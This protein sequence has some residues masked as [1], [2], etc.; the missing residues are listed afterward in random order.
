MINH[1]E[2]GNFYNGKKVLVCGASGMTGRNLFELF[3]NMNID[4]YGTQLSKGFDDLETVDLTDKNR[5]DALISG[6]RPDFVFICAAKTYNMAVCKKDPQSM[7][8]PNISMVGNTLES[9]LNNDVKRVLY[10]S[11]A[12]VYQ[13]SYKVLAE[14]D[15]DLNQ[16]P[17]DVYLGVGWMKRYA[18]KLC[19]FYSSIGL[20]TVVVRP[21]NIY[22]RYDKNDDSVSHVVPALIQ[23]ALRR[24]DP[25]VVYGNGRSVK[26]FIYVMDFVEDLATVMALHSTPDP[27]N[28]CSG[29]LISI[30]DVVR[31]IIK[32]TGLSLSHDIKYTSTKHDAVPFRGISN[33][34][35]L[36]LFG[37]KSYTKFETG[38]KET[39]QWFS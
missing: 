26:D 2:L 21:T 38:L 3:K 4:V 33:Q 23:R 31:L 32:N 39:I 16:E 27:I 22:G 35:F 29:E 25:F 18:E 6:I 12:T 13:P 20:Q 34:K 24:E 30:R 7:V 15:L 14:E 11:S 10:I 36:A 1:W 37:N 9:C 5:V 28:I 19:K 17:H 8:L